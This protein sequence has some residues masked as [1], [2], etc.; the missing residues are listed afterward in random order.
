MRTMY[1]FGVHPALVTMRLIGI[2]VAL[3]STVAAAVF[4]LVRA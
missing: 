1:P 2:A 3:F 4:F